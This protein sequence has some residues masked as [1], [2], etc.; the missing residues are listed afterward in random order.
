MYNAHLFYPTATE[1]AGTWHNM[2]I[3]L[4]QETGRRITMAIEDPIRKQHICPALVH[5]DSEGGMRSP[6]EIL[7]SLE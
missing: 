6:S 3:E 1:T 4:T 2:A 7:Y 5:G